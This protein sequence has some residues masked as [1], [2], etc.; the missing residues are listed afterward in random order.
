VS[1]HFPHKSRSETFSYVGREGHGAL[2]IA[3]SV[4]VLG[5][6]IGIVFGPSG[7]TH[8]GLSTP[9]AATMAAA[10]NREFQQEI[11]GGDGENHVETSPVLEEPRELILASSPRPFKPDPEKKRNLKVRSG[12][13]L[14]SIMLSA[15][16]EHED[17]HDAVS[18]LRSVYDPRDLRVGQRISLTL[19][20]N[21]LQ[22]M[23]LDPSVI[24]QIAVRRDDATSF[25]AFEVQRTLT[26]RVKFSEGVITSSLYKAAVDRKVPLSVLAELMRIYSWD[27][28]FQREIQS[29]DRFEV[30]YDKFVDDEGTVIRH[31]E[32]IYARLT[33][34]GD[35]KP[36]YR[37]E[38]SP[39]TVDYF[40]NQGRSAKRP[41]LRTPIDG[42]RL[43]SLFGKR[44]HPVLGYTK[45]H[46][47]VD[48]AAATGTPIYAAGDGVI[49]YRGR[50]GGYG[51]YISIRH[52]GGFNTAYA[53]MSRFNS[54]V[55][56]GDRVRQ[57][58]VIGYVGTTGRS[59]GPHLHYEILAGDRQGNPL[60]V[61]MPSGIK[62]GKKDFA[63]F[64]A[65]RA[66]IDSL[67]ANLQKETLI[68][69][70]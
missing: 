12:D 19:S 17:A 53:H 54:K 48:F 38:S 6:S 36:L 34:S 67:V 56:L 58:E 45:M 69:Q 24:R 49:S 40:D 18:A 32:V 4:L 52:A 29:G 26:R 9:L 15:G 47:G 50:K 30:A 2:H 10:G 46:R 35:D 33:L 31:G 16:I 55:T 41:L 37:F 39:G 59:T 3:L 42:A 51:N 28:D 57:G 25:R 13:T 27:V 22:E 1:L 63:R 66:N 7:D 62:L 20:D 44:R 14:M 5:L 65:K 60:T 23:R 68:S 11:Q 43:S 21:G 8:A 70:R 61:K 64:M